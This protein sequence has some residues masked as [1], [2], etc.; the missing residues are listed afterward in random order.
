M[1]R[2]LCYAAMLSAALAFLCIFPLRSVETHCRTLDQE[3]ALAAEA[4]FRGD[5][6]QAAPHAEAA[7]ELWDC[8][9]PVANMYL[10]HAELDPVKEAIGEMLARLQTGETD[11]FYAACCQVRLLVRHLSESERADAGNIL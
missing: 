3:L 4:S 6:V 7:G 11:E 10:R 5:L 8:W 9:Q 2:R 1:I